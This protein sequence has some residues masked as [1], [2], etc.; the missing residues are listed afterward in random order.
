MRLS[1]SIM[2]ILMSFMSSAQVIIGPT[3]GQNG[4]TPKALLDVRASNPSAPIASDGFLLPR[5][6]YFPDADQVLQ[7]IQEGTLMIYMPG[8]DVTPEEGRIIGGVYVYTELEAW[9]LLSLSGDGIDDDGDAPCVVI[10][11]NTGTD[12]LSCSTP[13]ITLTASGAGPHN[14]NTGASTASITVNTPGTYTVQLVD[15]NSSA[16]IVITGDSQDGAPTAVITNNTGTTELTSEVTQIEVVASGGD[17]YSWNT[18]ET[19]AQLTITEAGTY[20]VTV[21]ASNGCTDTASIEITE[22]GGCTPTELCATSFEQNYGC[23]SA[24]DFGFSQWDYE[25][26]YSAYSSGTGNLRLSGIDFSPYS[27]IEISFWYYLWQYGGNDKLVLEYSLNGSSW[28]ELDQYTAED[29]WYNAN[30]TITNPALMSSNLQ[31]RI[32]ADVNNNNDYTFID[33]TVV[34][35]VCD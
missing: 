33:L 4:G 28:T 2:L 7:G 3:T 9:E 26:S 6:E 13:E 14:W 29:D 21:T 34:T 30:Y 18:G 17:S 5:L 27:S 8:P 32:R 20:T 19:T 16:S 23:W 15:C 12:V 25:G 31:L 24:S 22:E 35:G 11:N 10:Q 1:I